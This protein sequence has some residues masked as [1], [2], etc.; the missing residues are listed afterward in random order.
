MNERLRSAWE[1]SIR[2]SL[3]LLTAVVLVAFV[4]SATSYQVSCTSVS[5]TTVFRNGGVETRRVLPPV[6]PSPSAPYYSVASWATWPPVS[7]YGRRIEPNPQGGITWL[8]HGQDSFDLDPVTGGIDS[9][10]NPRTYTGVFLTND[11]TF[12]LWPLALLLTIVVVW[13][14]WRRLR[15][16]GPDLCRR[17]GYDRDGLIPDAKCPECG[18]APSYE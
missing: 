4:L 17:C 1:A 15:F 13:L 7:S 8:P 6:I 12:P 9:S 5:G 11:F 10:T 3:T 16:R 2:W 14:W 18:T